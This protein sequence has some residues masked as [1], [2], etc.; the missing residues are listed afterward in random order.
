MDDRN[1]KDAA[2]RGFKNQCPNCGEGRVLRSYLKIA[3]TCPSCGEKLSRAKADDGPA[4]LTII[5]VGHLLVP[6]MGWLYAEFDPKPIWV[7]VG[8]CG[9]AT[10]LS[11]LLLPRF[12]GMIVGIQWAKRMYGF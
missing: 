9:T 1:A 8:F 5:V 10:L 4:Y 11:L 7:A 3:D 6:I 2:W 12:K